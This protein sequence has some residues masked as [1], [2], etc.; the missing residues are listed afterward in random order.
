MFCTN[1]SQH[2]HRKQRAPRRGGKRASPTHRS[3]TFD[4]YE[5]SLGVY[6]GT[7]MS[8]RANISL[9]IVFA[10]FSAKCAC[11]FP[12]WHRHAVKRTAKVGQ[13]LHAALSVK[14]TDLN[15]SCHGE[16]LP[17]LATSSAVFMMFEAAVASHRS[18]WSASPIPAF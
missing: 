4:R 16:C 10:S 14:Q 1:T 5:G 8:P 11:S 6:P 9:L 2:N 18:V 3:Q 17:A 7:K 15:S 13:R 12:V